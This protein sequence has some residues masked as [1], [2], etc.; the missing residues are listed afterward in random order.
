L[1]K[2]SNNEV[3]FGFNTNN[4][5]IIIL[6]FIFKNI[7]GVGGISQALLFMFGLLDC[8]KTLPWYI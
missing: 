1:D 2:L 8:S 4:L 7:L 3:I 6:I 5:E